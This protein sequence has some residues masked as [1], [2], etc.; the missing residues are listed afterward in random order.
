MKTKSKYS[1]KLKIFLYFIINPLNL[2]YGFHSARLISLLVSFHFHPAT[3]PEMASIDSL[4]FIDISAL[5]Q[6]ELRALSLCSTSAFDLNRLDDVVIPTID[7]SLFNE[8]A[9][10]RRQTFSRPSTTTHHHHHHPIRHRISGLLPSSKHPAS[11]LPPHLD[12][13]HLENRS[14]LNFL[15]KSLSQSPQF[16]DVV[17]LFGTNSGQNEQVLRKRKRGR[18]PKTKVKSLEENLDIVNKNGREIDII[19][20]GSLEDPFGEELRRRTEGMGGNEEALL[21]FMRD[22]GGQWCSRR[23]KRKIVDANLLGDSLPVGWKLL[24]GL[25]RREG[26]A[27]VYCRR[28]IR[29]SLIY[30]TCL[31]Y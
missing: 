31:L 28:Y 16:H 30:S 20:L 26:R 18:K 21:G 1:L 29:F 9:G 19:A 6:S 27:S 11:S 24:L 8:S 10:S 17:S 15:K 2:P 22:L 12:P 7:R 23:R 5:S 13:E 14:I 25:K 4:P 3:L